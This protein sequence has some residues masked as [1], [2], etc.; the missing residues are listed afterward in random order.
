MRPLSPLC[1]IP[2]VLIGCRDHGKSAM[3]SVSP[4]QDPVRNT[5]V[6]PSKDAAVVET[7]STGQGERA[8][9]PTM[10]EVAERQAGEP[11]M[12]ALEPKPAPITNK[13]R[14]KKARSSKDQAIEEAVNLLRSGSYSAGGTVRGSSEPEVYGG[15][16]GGVM[17]DREQRQ[18]E[19]AVPRKKRDAGLK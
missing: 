10:T 9:I 3:D 14:S 1:L 4:N 17:S 15:V 13:T 11:P 2:L 16:Y 18:R 8:E 12:G 7:T 6:I 19:Q 5:A